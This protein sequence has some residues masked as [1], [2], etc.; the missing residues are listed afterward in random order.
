MPVQDNDDKRT[1]DQ[2]AVD[3]EEEL[4]RKQAQAQEQQQ[5]ESGAQKSDK[6][7][8][9]LNAKAE[10]H[11][12]RIDSLDEKIAN[13]TD[14]IDRNKAK[15]EALSAKADKLEDTNRMLKATIGNLPGIRTLI[16][17]N[18]KRIQAIREVKIPKR[19][20]KIDQG[21]KKIDTLTAKRDRIEHKLNRV[22]ALNDTIKSFGI[23]FNKE[24]REAFADAMTRLNSSTVDCLSDKKA[25]LEAKK[26][27]ILDTYNAPET[28]AVDKLKLGE[29]LKGV[30]ERIGAL[31]SKIMKLARPE[32][33]YEEQT[34]DQLD[35][36]MILTGEKL[37]EMV[38]NGTMDIPSLAEGAVQAAQEVE[39]L[40]RSQVASIADKLIDQPLASA[41]MQ[42]EDDYNMIDGI[43]NNGSKEDIDKARAELREGIKNMENL[44]ENPFVPQEMREN[45]TA[46]LEKMR[47]QLELLDSVDEIEVESW[48]MT[49]VDNGDAVLTD[50][51]GFKVNPDY[52]KE[53]PRGDRHVETMTEIQAVE[54]MSALTAAGVAYSAATKGEDKVGITVSKN[55]VPALNDVMYASIG[56]IAHTEAAKENGGKGEKGKYQTINPEYYASLGKDDKHTRVEPIATARKIVAE[57][58]KQNIPYSA[59]VRKN[60]TVAVTVSKANVE[61]YKQIESAV[62]GERAVEYVNPDFFKSLPKQERFTQRMDEGQARKKSAEL[63]AKGVE[64]SAV[65]GGEKS[66]VTV[67]KKDSQRAFFSRGRMQRDAQ[68]ISGRGQQK[69]QQREQTPKK[70][71]NQGLE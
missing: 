14:K 21:W 10:H 26:Q 1:T 5:E 22:I 3:A 47:K 60:D 28:S 38:Q 64:H 34:N 62:K 32:T 35:A 27:A 6:L 39:T 54:V 7:L 18:E 65:F 15:I 70:R 55:D 68:R 58:Q 69:S 29:Q 23:H 46:E 24:R 37:G 36:S 40:D 53:L 19:Q 9:F 17:N 41:E 51:G 33:H 48:L 2:P 25:T 49:M 13:Q 4:R 44:A 59:V 50:D 52:Y 11:Q 57:L 71:K 8:P 61:A 30:N 12:S 20:E 67:A 66:A 63:T 45:A 43:I 31:E 56:K 16:A 42:M